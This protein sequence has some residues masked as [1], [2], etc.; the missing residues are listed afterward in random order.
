MKKVGSTLEQMETDVVHELD[1]MRD[2]ATEAE[3]AAE[4]GASDLAERAA[5]GVEQAAHDFDA[6]LREDADRASALARRI[7]GQ[8]RSDLRNLRLE[9][10]R[11]LDHALGRA[12]SRVRAELVK[13]GEP[14]H[15][16]RENDDET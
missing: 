16:S 9:V 14:D 7:D 10:L 2:R 6:S 4:D 12:H 3:H 5:R 13:R 15:G 11:D 1:A 8:L